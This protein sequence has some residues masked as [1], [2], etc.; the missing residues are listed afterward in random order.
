MSGYFQSILEWIFSW[1]G[2]FGWSIVI[3]T[4]FVRLVLLPL[5]IKSKKSM[6]SMSKVQP[7]V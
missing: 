1:V 6:R 2:N 7:K 3:F 5:D 4:L